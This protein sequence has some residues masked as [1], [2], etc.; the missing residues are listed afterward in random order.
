MRLCV[1]NFRLFRYHLESEP[2]P[3]TFFSPHLFS[4]LLAP[5]G[6]PSSR[7]YLSFVSKSSSIKNKN[8]TA[9]QLIFRED[10]RLFCNR[11]VSIYALGELVIER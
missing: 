10:T 3:Q 8:I 11:K 5:R 1:Q 9:D 2:H 7:L 4:L 6:F